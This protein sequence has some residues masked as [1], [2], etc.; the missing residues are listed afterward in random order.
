MADDRVERK[1][2]AILAADVVGYTRLMNEDEAG[3]LARLKALR[4]ELFEPKTEEHRG[5]IFKTT[6]DGALVEFKSAADAVNSAVEIQ[7][8][9]A[10]RE[11]DVPEDR[12]IRLR[13]GVSLGDMIVEGNDLYG[14]GVNVAARMEGLAESGGIC[15]SGNVHEHVRGAA[16]LAFDDL[17][18]Q[19]VKKH[20]GA[21]ARLSRA[22][23]ERPYRSVGPSSG[24][25]LTSA[26]G[27]AIHCRVAISEY[28]RRTGAGLLL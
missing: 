1:L 11:A 6:G 18:H 20:S 23:R 26:A 8:A 2:A 10:E 27:Q 16:G 13:I 9:L 4:R 14:R 19:E 28:E 22:P 5:R 3:T 21:G 17:G 25:R 12:R 24:R 7:H 15:I